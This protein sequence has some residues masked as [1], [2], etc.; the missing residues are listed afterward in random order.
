M[1]V[2]NFIVISLQVMVYQILIKGEITN[3]KVYS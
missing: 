3:V 2:C 1:E